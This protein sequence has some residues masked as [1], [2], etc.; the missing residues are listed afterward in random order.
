MAQAYQLGLS[1][2]QEQELR[3]ARDHHPKA[4]SSTLGVS[5]VL[6]RVRSTTFCTVCSYI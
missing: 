1:E 4:Y 2:S 3:Q 5:I 6:A